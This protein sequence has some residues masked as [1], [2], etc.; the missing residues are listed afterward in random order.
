[1]GEVIPSAGV[2]STKVG[3]VLCAAC[4]AG[5]ETELGELVLAGGWER[6]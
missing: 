3:A 2:G 1:M 4:A 5:D 6:E